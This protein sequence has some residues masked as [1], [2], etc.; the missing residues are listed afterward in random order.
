M[1]FAIEG[2]I[3]QTNSEGYLQNLEDWSVIVA[4]FLATQD[5]LVLTKDHWAVIYLI[6]D[7]YKNHH[8]APGI[9]RLVRSIGQKLGENKANSRYLYQ[10]FPQ[11]PAKQ[12]CKYAGLPKPPGCI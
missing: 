5:Q 9:R 6:R 12:A 7:Y 11:G 8:V 3:Y 1:T 2:K 4:E 10:L